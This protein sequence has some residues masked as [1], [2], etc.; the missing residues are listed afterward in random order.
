MKTL[1]E[2]KEQELI[3]VEQRKRLEF[4]RGDIYLREEQAIADTILPFFSEFTPEV[5]VEVTRGSV[6]FVFER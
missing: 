4:K 3:L 6:Y 5:T 2:L 1:N